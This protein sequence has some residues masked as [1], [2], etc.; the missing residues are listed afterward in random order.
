MYT[1]L[2]VGSA[3]LKLLDSITLTSISNFVHPNLHTANRGTNCTIHQINLL[4][5]V[6]HTHYLQCLGVPDFHGLVK[7]TGDKHAC[8]I[9]IPLDCLDTEFVDMQTRPKLKDKVINY[10]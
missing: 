10:S 5:N 2:Y 9:R 3:L 4:V 6:Y 1:I 8:V 7:R